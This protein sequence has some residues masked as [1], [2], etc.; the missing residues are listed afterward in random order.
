M[1]NMDLQN[2]FGASSGILNCD[3]GYNDYLRVQSEGASTQLVTRMMR[4]TRKQRE[5]E[6][7][8]RVSS[9]CLSRPGCKGKHSRD[10]SFFSDAESRFITVEKESWQTRQYSGGVTWLLSSMSMQF[11]YNLIDTERNTIES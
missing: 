1:E 8:P 4:K 6:M 7:G 2:F 11:A 5:H 10:E 9:D 3:H